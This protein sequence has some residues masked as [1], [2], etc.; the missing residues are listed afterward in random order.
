MIFKSFSL[1]NYLINIQIHVLIILISKIISEF[2]QIFLFFKKQKFVV[3]K[4]FLFRMNRTQRVIFSDMI[5]VEIVF[6][7]QIILLQEQLKISFRINFFLELYQ[8][9]I[10]RNVCWDSYKINLIKNYFSSSFIN[11]RW[12]SL[13]SVYILVIS[14]WIS[15]KSKTMFIKCSWD[16]LK[17]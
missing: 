15:W 17:R 9:L 14:S 8:Q 2:F 5:G 13:V 3:I 12:T 6:L 4:I 16:I 11:Y 1:N 10:K 7:L